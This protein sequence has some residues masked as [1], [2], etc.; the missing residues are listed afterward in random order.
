VGRRSLLNHNLDVP[1]P[2]R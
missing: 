2:R 1:H